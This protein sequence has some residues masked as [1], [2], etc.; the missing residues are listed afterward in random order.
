[1]LFVKN[2]KAVEAEPATR[3]PR[4]GCVVK[5]GINGFEGEAVL[6]NISVAGFRMESRTY[7]TIGVGEYYVMQIKSDTASNLRPFEL[8]VEARWVQSAETNFSAGFLVVKPPSDRSFER[9]VDY[10]RTQD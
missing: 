4:Y 9:Y 7:V 2:K 3:A 10:I 6:K 5:V 8:G 1:M